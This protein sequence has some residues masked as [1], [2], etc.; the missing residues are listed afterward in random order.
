MSLSL[1]V[2]LCITMILLDIVI[3]IGTFSFKKYYKKSLAGSLISATCVTITYL[4]SILSD[5]YFSNSLFSSLYFISVDMEVVFLAF[6]ISDFCKINNKV[7]HKRLLYLFPAYAAVD[8][9]LF[10]IN[11]FK[12]IVISYSYEPDALAHW[13]YV[14]ML[15]YKFHLVFCYIMILY[16]LA[17]LII[18]IVNTPSIIVRRYIIVFCG[19]VLVVIMNAIFLFL[20]QGRFFDFSILFYSILCFIIY[21]TNNHYSAQGV[22]SIVSQLALSKLSMPLVLFDADNNYTHHND[23]AAFLIPKLGPKEYYTLDDFIDRWHFRNHIK[24]TDSDISFQWEYRNENEGIKIY[25]C[26]YIVL[27]SK[28]GKTIAHVFMFTDYSLNYDLLTGFRTMHS[29]KQEYEDNNITFTYPAGVAICDINKLSEINKTYGKDAG[30]NAVCTLANAIREFTPQGT[31]YIR[32]NDANLLFIVN[33]TSII[34]MRHIISSIEEKLNNYSDNPFTLKMQS[35]IIMSTDENPSIQN[36]VY[37]A[38]K[39]MKA[40]K[41]MD[42]QSAHSSL[43]DSFAQTLQESDSCTKEHVKRTQILGEKLG[44]RLGLSDYDLSNLALLCLLHDIGKLG[45][46]LD[47]LNKPTK[48]SPEEWEVMRSHTEKGYR[49]AKASEELEDI[50]VFI[51]HH[52]ECWNGS[53][54]PDGLKQESI[55]LL[56]RIIAVV[57]TFDAMTNDRPYR[58]ALSTSHA[59]KELL[60]CAGSQFDPYIVTEFID[61]LQSMN[62]CTEDDLIL[63]DEEI[64]I[65]PMGLETESEQLDTSNCCD[66][67]YTKYLLDK[68]QRIIAIDENFETI[69]G[70]SEEDLDTYNLHQIDLIFP[71]DADT[72]VK[73]VKKQLEKNHEAFVEHRIRRKDGTSKRVFCDGREFFDSVTREP[74]VQIIAT[75]IALSE[76]VKQIV[77]KERD[78]Q[79]RSFKRWED[80]VRCDALTGIYNRM[81]F[82]ND[83]SLHLLNIKTIMAFIM[84][85][86]DYFKSFNDTYGHKRGDELLVAFAKSLENA[87][88]ERGMAARMGG[89]EFSAM[90]IYDK[91]AARKTIENDVEEIWNKVNDTVRSFESKVTLSMGI[92]LSN[93]SFN[94]FDELYKAADELLY[95]AK[96]EG[97]NHYVMK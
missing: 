41:M 52:H 62:I 93:E 5:T 26:D 94:T 85:D 6:Y 61:M 39:S 1:F 75:D 72:Y 15:P 88:G 12:E 81:A 82:Q 73:L 25:R 59:C 29:F 18:K 90:L 83:V 50:A 96:A 42:S 40:K 21:W 54:Y 89:D 10:L 14:P 37:L 53:G 35:A 60:R 91:G 33:D 74:R 86:M 45:I 80:T 3:I 31:H 7:N 77:D 28:K 92:V 70:Y 19:I 66:V 47:I 32:L 11:P 27:R 71:E 97:R 76:T 87:V 67:K 78:S 64:A 84:I 58:K 22:M 24:D 4:L 13:R 57:D 17:H 63:S 48:L 43:L 2:H 79:R 16:V 38:L 69:T 46:P 34:K 44:I 56:S 49:I 9:V 36:A 51:L 65:K 30:D 8:S 68:T 95:E 20:P 55:P 23:S